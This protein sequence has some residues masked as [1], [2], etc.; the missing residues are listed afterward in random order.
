M[1]VQ[2]TISVSNTDYHIVLTSQVVLCYL[3]S[4]NLKLF[5]NY[6]TT[7]TIPYLISAHLSFGY[8][9]VR[10]DVDEQISKV[11][12]VPVQYLTLSQM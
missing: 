11:H 9:L 7:Y 4:D 6:K 3:H 8:H 1:H 2:T 10:A 12:S 5:N